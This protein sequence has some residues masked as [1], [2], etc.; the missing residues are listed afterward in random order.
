M[1]AAL[2]FL[3][4]PLPPLGGGSDLVAIDSG[5]TGETGETGDTGPDLGQQW[6]PRVPGP[7]D[8]LCQNYPIKPEREDPDVPSEH[9][10]WTAGGIDYALFQHT[11]QVLTAKFQLHGHPQTMTQVCEALAFHINAGTDLDKPA[12]GS[13][14][15]SEGSGEESGEGEAKFLIGDCPNLLP[16][17]FTDM[18][19]NLEDWY[20]F[21]GT[22][23]TYRTWAA[24]T[25]IVVYQWR[26][27]HAMNQTE[28]QLNEMPGCW[29]EYRLKGPAAVAPQL[30]SLPAILFA[31]ENYGTATVAYT[32][33]GEGSMVISGADYTV[34]SPVWYYLTGGAPGAASPYHVN[35]LLSGYPPSSSFILNVDTVEASVLDDVMGSSPLGTLAPFT[36]TGIIDPESDEA[37]RKMDWFV[38]ETFNECVIPGGDGACVTVDTNSSTLDLSYS[39]EFD[40]PGPG[41]GFP[42]NWPE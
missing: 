10:I 38:F 39:G 23:P 11:A 2:F 7:Y 17:N 28:A 1:L 31:M 4:C 3:A 20:T 15:S 24:F 32:T 19:G 34:P 42:P 21:S 27:T 33:G 18:P 36:G 22:D 26:L 16:Q 14:R 25:N 5:D 12:L 35:F 30:N 6:Q 37:I 9:A 29:L 8:Q 41:P 40:K 13:L